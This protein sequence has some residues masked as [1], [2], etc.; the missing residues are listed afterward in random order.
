MAST[1]TNARDGATMPGA[2]HCLAKENTAAA[3]VEVLWPDQ[4]QKWDTEGLVSFR[5]AKCIYFFP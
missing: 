3:V 2:P 4:D 1:Q 5:F